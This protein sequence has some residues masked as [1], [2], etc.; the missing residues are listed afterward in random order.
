VD[1]ARYRGNA[2]RLMRVA[3]FAAAVPIRALTRGELLTVDDTISQTFGDHYHPARSQGVQLEALRLACAEPEI[4]RLPPRAID[5]LFAA[6]ETVQGEHMPD[7]DRLG[8]EVELQLA[9]GE[10]SLL[11]DAHAAGHASS[12]ADFFGVPTGALTDGQ[13]AYYLTLRAAHARWADRGGGSCTSLMMLRRRAGR[14]G[15]T[16]GRSAAR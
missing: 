11:S 3:G 14:S 2:P 6:W 9:E 10:G 16:R 8:A 1:V 12:P 15:T 13:L 7:I 5:S 4:G